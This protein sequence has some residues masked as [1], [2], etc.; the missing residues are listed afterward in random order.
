MPRNYKPR[1]NK[2]ITENKLNNHNNYENIKK[3]EIFAEENIFDNKQINEQV[4]T[5]L[6]KNETFEYNNKNEEKDTEI[7][8]KIV[9][10]SSNQKGDNENLYNDEEREIEALSKLINQDIM[11]ELELN[12]SVNVEQNNIKKS[13]NVPHY[14]FDRDEQNGK[15]KI[16]N[17]KWEDK[18]MDKKEQLTMMLRKV[19]DEINKM[20]LEIMILKK[21][22]SFIFDN[23]ELSNIEHNINNYANLIEKAKNRK[24]A[25]EELL[26]E[27]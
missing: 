27:I 15:L 19:N 26:G 7:E 11:K 6:N 17:N 24:K 22:K 5:F 21:I 16:I 14:V 1:S 8:E 20:E 3:E 10:S 4:E 25:I 12:K 2:S 18:N 9:S 23:N 13:D